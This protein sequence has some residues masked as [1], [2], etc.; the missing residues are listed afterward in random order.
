MQDPA[1]PHTSPEPRISHRH[2]EVFR[3]LM[4]SGSATAAA[5]MLFSSQPTVSRELARLESLLG[6]ALFE[7]AQGRLR[8]TARALSLWA[9]VQRSWQGLDRV[10]EHALALARPHQARI[11]VLCLPAL[12]HALLPAALARLHAEHGP[13]AVS[14]ATQEA[15][16]LQ[17]WMAAQRYDLGLAEL[18]E[19][20]PGTR[21]LALPAMDEVAV[22]P[23][24]HALAARP[25]LEAGDF[26]GEGFISLARDDP[27]RQQI[28]AVFEQAGV[29]RQ[30]HLE[31]HSAVAVCAMVQHG[32]GVA[33]VNPLT[34]RVCAGPQLVVRPLAF[35]I[36]FQ[37]H[38]LLPLHRPAVAEAQWLVDALA[39]EVAA[40]A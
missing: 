9:E 2:L 30:L 18:A 13:V 40:V 10:V 1:L 36:P 28:D 8:P 14:V 20:P 39:A 19:A 25:V 34:A 38:A 31:T 6:Y 3:A 26:A 7:R 35:S 27:Y 5:Q 16:L 21:A 11:N 12:S 23:A 33:I 17:E 4:L 15:P 29:Q 32:L 22:L 37:V 24:G